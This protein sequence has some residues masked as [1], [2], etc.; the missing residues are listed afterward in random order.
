M[1]RASRAAGYTIGAALA[2]SNLARVAA[3]GRRFEEA[4]ELFAESIASF[5]TIE[6]H[7]Y[8]AEARARLAECAVLEGRHAEAIELATAVLAD[9]NAAGAVRILAERVL[10][11]ALHQAR[12]PD[13]GRPHFEESLRLAREGSSDYETALT[14]RAIADT[15]S[16]AAEETDRAGGAE[17]A[18]TLARLGVVS[19]PS[20]PLP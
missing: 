17:A 14:L 3:R 5:E 18:A 9:E 1:L 15:A 6:A 10:G 19:L 2:T 4:R 20:V 16:G 13:D 11:Y 7:Y 8:V 12:R